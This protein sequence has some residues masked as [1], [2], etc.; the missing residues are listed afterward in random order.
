MWV[1]IAIAVV[2]VAAAVA[3]RMRRRATPDEDLNAFCEQLTTEIAESGPEY[4][5]RGLVPGT[6]TMVVSVRGQEVPVPLDNIFRHYLL[7]P[8]QIATLARQLLTE[9]EEVGLEGPE[10]RLFSDSAMQILPQ[11]CQK[12]WVFQHGPA[13]GDGALVHREL[14]PDLFL[15]YVIDDPWSVVFLSNAHL[16]HW[17]RTEQDMFHLASQN[18]RRLTDGEVRLPDAKDGPVKIHSGDGYDAAR[19]LLLDPDQAGDLL[20]A[21]PERETLYLAREADLESLES[22]LRVTDQDPFEHPVSTE[23]Y[24]LEA[25]R[26]VPVRDDGDDR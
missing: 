8:E 10:D 17:G 6:F 23:L 21:M 14:G 25:Q 22:L 12:D 1:W 4:G 19:V 18:L 16:R 15:C 2:L 24:R 26:L 20:V 3:W 13:F 9:I 11:V 5:V 7:Y